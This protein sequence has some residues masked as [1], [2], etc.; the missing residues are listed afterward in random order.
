MALMHGCFG[1]SPAAEQHLNQLM[2]RWRW[3]QYWEGST[4]LGSKYA[5]G[6]QV[7]AL[8]FWRKD[9]ASAP[10]G[11]CSVDLG[12]CQFYPSVSEVVDHS[13]MKIASAEDAPAA[14]RRFLAS[15]FAQDDLHPQAEDYA[16]ELISIMLPALDPPSAVQD[17]K[18]RPT[19]EIETLLDQFDCTLDPPRCGY[20]VMIPFY[21][22]SDLWTPVY[23]ECAKNC[24]DPSSP[25]TVLFPKLRDGDWWFGAAGTTK[26]PKQV[27]RIRRQIE[28]ALMVEVGR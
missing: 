9:D 26:D 12:V 27:Q 18:R 25:P 15:S 4:E 2:E 28:N 7:R 1:Q 13:E 11:L 20:H 19:E 8:L 22:G 14:F 17:R 16:T 21:A 6:T 24:P 3:T 23:M 10:L 5:E